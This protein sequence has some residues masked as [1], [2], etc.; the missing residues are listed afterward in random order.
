MSSSTTESSRSVSI[1]KLLPGMV[2][3]DSVTDQERGETLLE[4]G[5]QLTEKE[6]RTLRSRNIYNVRIE[7]QSYR[8]ARRQSDESE[9]EGISFS[10]EELEDLAEEVIEEDLEDRSEDQK[11]LQKFYEQSIEIVKN[12][13]DGVRN[14]NRLECDDLQP[15][16]SSMINHLT[17][18]ADSLL[19]IARNR[20][21]DTYLYSHSVNVAL[22]TIHLARQ[23]DID[24]DQLTE[25]GI[26]SILHDIGMANVSKD[27]LLKEGALTDEE[28]KSVQKHPEYGHQLVQAKENLSNIARTVVTQHHEKMDGS[29]YPRGLQGD[30]VS[31]YSRFVAV[32]DA[33]D[34]M[35]SPRT[36][37]KRRSSYEAMQIIIREGG[38]SFDQ[39]IA[40]YFYQ[41]MSIYP[42]GTLVRLNDGAMGIVQ[43]STSAPMRPVIKVLTDQEGAKLESPD[44]V[45]LLEDKERFISNVIDELDL[46]FEGEFN[47]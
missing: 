41:N 22:L 16:V 6:I 29:G 14:R 18:D 39:S 19:L 21:S 37:N 8:E 32:T 25:L 7:E 15:L 33:F 10:T 28:Y 12:V 23:F 9:S 20:S 42:I 30:D 17:R 43:R 31:V 45:N 27:V 38:S 1:D 3:S 47:E 2:I 11:E 24:R 36:Y 46:D 44:L 26:G 40:R 35:V 5:T 13:F 34:A 4:E